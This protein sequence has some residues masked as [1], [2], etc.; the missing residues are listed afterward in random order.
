MVVTLAKAGVLEVKEIR[1]VEPPP[2]DESKSKDRKT[3]QK[4]D[5]KQAEGPI[6]S[7]LEFGLSFA[8]R[9]DAIVKTLNSFAADSRFLVVRNLAFKMI[10]DDIITRMDADAAAKAAAATAAANTGRRRRRAAD[11]ASAETVEVKTGGLVADPEFGSPIQVDLTLIAW[12]FG[13]GGGSPAA[14]ASPA[15]AGDAA[16]APKPEK[17]TK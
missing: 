9:P 8:A 4:K 15:A 16:S 1:R 7:S 11:S 13:T 14:A 6:P 10:A 17:E 5:S 3:A 2:P 12:D